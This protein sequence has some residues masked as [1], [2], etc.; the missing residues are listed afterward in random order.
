MDGSSNEN[1]LGLDI[2]TQLGTQC[3]RVDWGPLT[4]MD[5]PYILNELTRCVQ[6]YGTWQN[7]EERAVW[8]SSRE[9]YWGELQAS[10]RMMMS[11]ISNQRMKYPGGYFPLHAEK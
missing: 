10:C 5:V 4:P 6:E 8:K 9:A 3:I 2:L 7:G 11:G 1:E